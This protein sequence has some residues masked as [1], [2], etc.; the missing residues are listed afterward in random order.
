[1]VFW[2]YILR[3]LKITDQ[4]VTIHS[5]INTITIHASEACAYVGA[6]VG[7]VENRINTLNL[8]VN[9]AHIVTFKKGTQTAVAIGKSLQQVITY[10]QK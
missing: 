4:S 1:M 10:L 5:K 7:I 8:N 9:H 3:S 6:C 2:R